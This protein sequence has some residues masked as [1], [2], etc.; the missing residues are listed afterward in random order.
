[1]RAIQP[2]CKL[3]SLFARSRTLDD[4]VSVRLPGVENEGV[5]AGISGEPVNA[6]TAVDGVGDDII[7]PKQSL[8]RG[9]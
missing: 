3:T 5:V 2:H 8:S 9:M 4:S 6:T 1:V 7:L